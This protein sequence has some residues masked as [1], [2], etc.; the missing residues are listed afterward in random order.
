MFADLGGGPSIVL[1]EISSS[2]T[3][4]KRRRTAAGAFSAM[5]GVTLYLPKQWLPAKQASRVTA[6]VETRF[7]Y[8]FRSALDMSTNPSLDDEPLRTSTADYGDLAL[9]GFAWGVSLF[10]RVM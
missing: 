4:A 10:I 5:G 2:Q 6:G 9:R 7:G 1:D 8:Q 3:A